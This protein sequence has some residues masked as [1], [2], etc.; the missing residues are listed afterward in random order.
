MN[1][2]AGGIV[3]V[4]P[5]IHLALG[6]GGDVQRTCTPENLVGHSK[7]PV[8]GHQSDNRARHSTDQAAVGQYHQAVKAIA[9]EAERKPIFA[10]ETTPES[11]LELSDCFPL[12][13]SL[14]ETSAHNFVTL[15]S[16]QFITLP[17]QGAHSG[18]SVERGQAPVRCRVCGG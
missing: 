5:P 12:N 4:F 14:V 13:T 8:T 10:G 3:E 16:I 17:G 2:V 15:R 7:F 18:T 11:W 6:G 1:F 9:Y